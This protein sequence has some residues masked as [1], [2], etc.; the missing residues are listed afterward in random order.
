MN[1]ETQHLRDCGGRKRCARL[2]C[3]RPRRQEQ[4]PTRHARADSRGELASA[5]EGGRGL[6]SSPRCSCTRPR[7]QYAL[8]KYGSRPRCGRTARAERRI[9][10]VVFEH[11]QVARDDRGTGSG[12]RASTI[13]CRASVLPAER[14]QARHSGPVMAPQNSLGHV[15]MVSGLARNLYL[16]RVVKSFEGHQFTVTRQRSAAGSLGGQMGPAGILTVSVP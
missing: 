10:P 7:V 16:V 15:A 9:P 12:V 14:A 1:G 2:P 5:W 3:A 11:G 6:S 13:S 4:A 8:T